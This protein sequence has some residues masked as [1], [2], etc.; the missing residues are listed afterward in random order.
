MSAA[1]SL[2]FVPARRTRS[3]DDVVEQIRSA[4]LDGRIKQGE[5]LP[6]ERDLCRIFQVSRSTLREGLRT[7]EVL[8]VVEIRPGS[9]GGIFASEP[10]GDQVS[11][12]LE[13]LLRF[14]GASAH[15][16]AEFRVGFEAETAYWAAVRAGPEDVAELRALAA[17]FGERAS[18][19]STTWQHLAGLD[20]KFHEAV[21]RASKNQVRVAIML[22]ISKAF[23]RTSGT[24]EP[25]A[26]PAVR[27]SI[28]NEL[29]E[30]AEAI[31]AGD[32]ELA[33]SRM[34]KHVR[35]FSG[36]GSRIEK[37]AGGLGHSTEV[38]AP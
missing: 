4:V 1:S 7:L 18:D 8:G 5:R 11:F 25:L 27:R 14:Q 37:E 21:V 32:A 23:L 12:A 3:F 26:S 15:D 36:L 24:M 31:A 16:L 17:E 28:G 9:A 38:G 34:Q 22:G 2:P 29:A 20:V 13:A 35:R 30:V 19:A 33:R 6:N 10:R